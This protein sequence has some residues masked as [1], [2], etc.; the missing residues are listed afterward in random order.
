M[1]KRFLVKCSCGWT[2]PSNGT[3]SDLDDLKEIVNC[4][5]CGKLRQFRCP[6]CQGKATQFRIK[7]NIE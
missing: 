4:S 5:S 2:R 6:K 3:P 1:E 7:G